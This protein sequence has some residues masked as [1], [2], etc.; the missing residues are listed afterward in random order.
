MRAA[1]YPSFRW[2]KQQHDCAH[3]RVVAFL[4]RIQTG[5]P[6]ART[7][8]VQYLTSF[9][10]DHTRLPDRMLAAY[11]RNRE[12]AI[13]KVIL[14]AGTRP[15]DSCGWMDANGNPL[16]PQT[17]EIRPDDPCKCPF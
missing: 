2:H 13:G 11:L 17:G 1:R 4:A 15:V 6:K 7:E 9:L 5:D 8:L 3:K 10:N 12:R 16:D 14:R